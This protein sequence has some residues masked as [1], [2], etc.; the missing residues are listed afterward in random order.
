MPMLNLMFIKHIHFKV[1][2]FLCDA[3]HGKQLQKW[4]YCERKMR[5]DIV[6]GLFVCCSFFLPLYGFFCTINLKHNMYDDSAETFEH[7]VQQ[8]C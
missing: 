7:N 5:L 8:C 3:V 1:L 6:P 2:I 4:E